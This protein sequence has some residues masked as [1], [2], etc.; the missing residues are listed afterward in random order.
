MERPAA[1]IAQERF[2]IILP[3]KLSSQL[4]G[5]GGGS[6]LSVLSID[7]QLDLSRVTDWVIELFPCPCPC[8]H[9]WNVPVRIPLREKNVDVLNTYSPRCPS[10]KVNDFTVKWL[11]VMFTPTYWDISCKNRHHGG[12]SQPKKA[13]FVLICEGKRVRGSSLKARVWLQITY[14]TKNYILFLSSFQWKLFCSQANK[15]QIWFNEMHPLGL[16]VM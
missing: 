10:T 14:R 15:L 11:P 8:A 3:H 6:L 5:S 9:C 16:C 13:N 7:I 12:C 1:C 2:W 4:E